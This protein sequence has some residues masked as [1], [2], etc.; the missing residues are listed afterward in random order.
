MVSRLKI[1]ADLDIAERRVPQDGIKFK[2]D[3]V[4]SV[5]L[6]MSTMPTIYGEKVVLRILNPESIMLDSQSG[7]QHPQFRQVQGHVGPTG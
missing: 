7:L 4:N 1:V 6:R 2:V 3:E 5:D